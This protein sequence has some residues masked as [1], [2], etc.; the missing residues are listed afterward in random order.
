VDGVESDPP[1]GLGEAPL[2]PVVVLVLL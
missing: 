1:V 2:V